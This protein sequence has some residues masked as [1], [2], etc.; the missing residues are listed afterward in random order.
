VVG[1]RQVEFT[2]IMSENRQSC[3]AVVLMSTV[4]QVQFG[5]VVFQT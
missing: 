5:R 4:G 2:E 1:R 3:T